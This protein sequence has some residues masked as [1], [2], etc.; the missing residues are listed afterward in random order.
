[1][2]RR[3]SWFVCT[4]SFLLLGSGLGALLPQG[5]YR[6]GAID[7]PYRVVFSKTLP[8][9][10][11]HTAGTLYREDEYLGALFNE[12][13]RKGLDPLLTETLGVGDGEQLMI[14]CRTR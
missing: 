3:L 12:L 13:D 5:K 4:A 6:K 8:R 2:R 11:G 1:M 10:T 9:A 7:G 14:V